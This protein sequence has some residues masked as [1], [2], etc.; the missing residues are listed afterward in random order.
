ME[1]EISPWVEKL[2]QH[3]VL[4]ATSLTILVLAVAFAWTW[5]RWD[6]AQDRLAMM[7]KKAAEGFL[8]APSSTRT[9][10][11]DPRAGQ[12][13][14]ID[15]GK[16]PQRIDLLISARTDRYGRFRLTLVRHDGTL[17]LHADRMARDSN[18]DLR[19]SFNTSILPGGMYMIL[20]EGYTR[21]GNLEG[22]AEARMQVVGK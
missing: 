20:I 8:Q 18:N 10:R 21:R 2:K 15:A 3:K 17:I 4:L 16:F 11:V 19:I 9:V 6:I 13:V 5:Y 12:L 14:R 7:E 1:T 22:F